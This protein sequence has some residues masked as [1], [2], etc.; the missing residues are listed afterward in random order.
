MWLAQRAAGAWLARRPVRRPRAGRAARAGVLLPG[1][2]PT[3]SSASRSGA[4]RGPSKQPRVRARRGQPKVVRSAARTCPTT[5][6]NQTLVPKRSRPGSLQYCSINSMR[7][8]GSSASDQ[9][10]VWLS[11]SA[12]KFPSRSSSKRTSTGP[13]APES[14][15]ETAPS[16]TRQMFSASASPVFGVVKLMRTLASLPRRAALQA[17]SSLRDD[18]R[19]G[20]LAMSSERDRDGV[21]AAARGQAHRRRPACVTR[22]RGRRTAV[23]RRP[24]CPSAR[25]SSRAARGEGA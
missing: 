15:R 9:T 7:S 17:D 2:R 25:G 19:E 22:A 3:P 11:P 8:A 23:G 5:F 12:V 20:D 10:A 24:A 21:A 6:S 13:K 18:R 14:S 4:S 16:L 1:L